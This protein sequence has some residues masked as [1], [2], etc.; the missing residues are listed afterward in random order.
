MA[1]SNLAEWYN[2]PA[3]TSSSGGGIATSQSGPAYA[4]VS[5]APSWF[6][7]I[8]DNTAELRGQYAD[9]GRAFSTS[10][11]DRG[12]KQQQSRLLTSSL[13]AGQNAAAEYANRARQAGGSAEG[14]GLV[15]AEAQTSARMQAGEQEMKRLKF[16]ADQRAAAAAHSVTI[17]NSLATMRQDYLTGASQ[18]VAHT[19]PIRWVKLVRFTAH[20]SATRIR[21]FPRWLPALLGISL[22]LPVI[23]LVWA[24]R[25]AQL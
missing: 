12:S 11:F 15:K 21:G 19:L 22:L 1:I 20:L 3:F 7:T 5:G 16:D 2:N 17:A 23:S 24:G 13:N 10:E 4:R 14:A 18:S 6:P 8:A 25:K 9:T